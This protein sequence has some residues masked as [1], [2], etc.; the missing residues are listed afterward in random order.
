MLLLLEST[1]MKVVLLAQSLLC[2]NPGAHTCLLLLLMLLEAKVGKT[3]WHLSPAGGA[4]H[5]QNQIWSQLGGSL[6]L[7]GSQAQ[8]PASQSRAKN[9]VETELLAVMVG[10]FLITSLATRHNIDLRTLNGQGN[11]GPGCFLPVH[12]M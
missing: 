12:A 9:G 11:N 10:A 8:P 5:W 2:R 4:S 7:H 3:K 6:G 1:A